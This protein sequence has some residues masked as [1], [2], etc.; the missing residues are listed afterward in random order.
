[1]IPDSLCVFSFAQGS[2]DSKTQG[3]SGVH[4]YRRQDNQE[5]LTTL[6]NDSMLLPH[7]RIVSDFSWLHASHEKESSFKAAHELEDEEL[8]L[9]GNYD[10][11]QQS[12]KTPS[13]DFYQNGGQS[14]QEL[15]IFTPQTQKQDK[16]T[17]GSLGDFVPK[18]PPQ[19]TS[20]SFASSY[21][22]SSECEKLKNI[23]KSVNLASGTDRN[24]QQSR[25]EKHLYP[26]PHGSDYEPAPKPAVKETN[27][28]QALESLQS[29]IKGK[30]SLLLLFLNFFFEKLILGVELQIYNGWFSH[31]T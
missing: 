21:L 1:M 27:V 9:Y 23:L 20:S 25:E 22:D 2:S 13:T 7:D 4:T 24:A 29:L 6:D 16:P 10:T 3:V 8:F 17:L 15:N 14:K 30:V 19:V 31:I 26:V 28:L 18:Q 12:S 11:T 5:N